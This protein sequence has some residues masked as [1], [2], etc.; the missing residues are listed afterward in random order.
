MTSQEFFAL[1][2]DVR[3]DAELRTRAQQLKKK[4][5]QLFGFSFSVTDLA[6]EGEDA[7]VVVN[8]LED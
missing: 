1:I 7:P 3:V 5:E 4:L 6:E 8:T 2:E